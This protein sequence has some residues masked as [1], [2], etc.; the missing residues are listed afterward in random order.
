MVDRGPYLRPGT[1]V[2]LD[3]GDD[4]QPEYG[5]VVHCWLNEEIDAHDCYVAFFGDALPSGKPNKI[6]YILR[7]LSTSLRVLDAALD[8]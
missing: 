3:G 2:R 5:V 4:S 7:Y 6:P 1:S 8:D